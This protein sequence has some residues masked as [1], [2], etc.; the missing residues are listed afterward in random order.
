MDK[1]R[2]GFAAICK[3]LNKGKFAEEIDEA[4]KSVALSSKDLGKAGSVTIKVTFAPI[5]NSAG[6]QIFIGGIVEKKQPVKDKKRS[7][8]YIGDDGQVQ[9]DNPNQ[10]EMSFDEDVDDEI[11]DDSDDEDYPKE[12]KTTT[13]QG[14]NPTVKEKK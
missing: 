9:R 7:L 14:E 12:R 4:I 1:P 2:E 10:I 13:K 5:A 3:T 6:R 11:V 8:F